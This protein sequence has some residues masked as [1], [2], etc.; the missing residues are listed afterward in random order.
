MNAWW[1]GLPPAEALVE[2]GGARHRV[3]W[4]AGEVS[5]PDHGDLEGE[6][7]LAALGG[8]RCV[9]A[10]VVDAWAAH[11]A[12]ERVLVLG[13]R[14]PSDRIVVREWGAA[15]EEAGYGPMASGPEAPETPDARRRALLSL[16]GAFGDRLVATVAAG[17]A[18]QPPTPVQHAAL[19]GRVRE[20]LGEIEVELL[21]PGSTP[22]LSGG[23]VALP[24]SWVAEVW[25][26]GLATVLGRF[27]LAAETTD[28]RS[29]RLATAEDVIRLDFG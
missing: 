26:R 13:R 24:F 21:A 6:R 28:G 17:L 4:E 3:R 7:A 20:V 14:G 2:C 11:A 16:P 8:D 15:D 12:D 10:D 5:T 23:R 1:L 27:V 9:C 19:Y 29:W 18:G 25:A 22:S